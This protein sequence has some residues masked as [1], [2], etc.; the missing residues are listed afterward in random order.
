MNKTL[1]TAIINGDKEKAKE[2]FSTVMADKYSSA[3]EAKKI[4]VA[5]KIYS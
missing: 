3:Y 2:I 1:I 4:A 5:T